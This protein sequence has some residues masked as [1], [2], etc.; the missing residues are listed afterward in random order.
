MDTAGFACCIHG[1]CRCGLGQLGSRP[2]F[3]EWDG[4]NYL[5]VPYWNREGENIIGVAVYMYDHNYGGRVLAIGKNS[6][7]SIC[8]IIKDCGADFRSK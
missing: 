8:I 5:A 1:M 6:D 3:I 7:S 4:T 2:Y